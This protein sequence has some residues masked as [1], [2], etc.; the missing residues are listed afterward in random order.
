MKLEKKHWIIIGIV[1]A[2]VVIWY[3]F[4]RKK[5]TE[6][7][8]NSNIMIP[9]DGMWGDQLNESGYA[10]FE[11]SE[12]NYARRAGVSRGPTGKLYS[13]EAG[14]CPC[15]TGKQKGICT[16]ANGVMSCR[17]GR[18]I[19]DSD[20]ATISSF[21]GIAS[22]GVNPVN[23]TQ[24]TPRQDCTNKGGQ[25]AEYWDGSKWVWGCMSKVKTPLVASA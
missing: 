18:I 23:P 16:K 2:V 21:R 6:S 17:E 19:L 15:G 14:E 12:S 11:V 13:A 7:S 22:V 24:N 9:G 1:V 5:A 20:T 8:F 10:G 25:W 4:F 3:F